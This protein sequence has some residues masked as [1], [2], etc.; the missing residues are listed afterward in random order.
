MMK[1]K[2][3]HVCNTGIYL[4]VLATTLRVSVFY[5]SKMLNKLYLTLI[6]IEM[7]KKFMIF[8]SELRPEFRQLV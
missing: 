1:D 4:F 7:V 6:V 8:L 5:I 3:T 2:S